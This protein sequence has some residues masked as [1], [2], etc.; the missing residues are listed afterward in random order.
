MLQLFQDSMA[1]VRH[2]GK[3][4]LFITFTANPKWKEI[5]DELLYDQ[6]AWDR[7]DLI[8]RVFRLKMLALL[9][10]L[11]ETQI[12]GRFKGYVWTIEYQKRG[13]PH[14]H[15]LLFLH[16]EDRFL[17]ADKI[18]QIVMAELPDAE[19]DPSGQLTELVKSMMVH[20]PCGEQAPRAPC[21]MSKDG[22]RTMTCSKKYPRAF[23]E[24]TSVLEDG[25]P[26]YRRRQ[27]GR[28]ISVKAPNNPGHIIQLDNRSVV[29]YN[30]Y[31]MKKYQAHINVEVCASVQAVKYIHK[32][33]Y[34]GGDRSTLELGS[35]NDE[36]KRYLQG[37]Y[38]GP[39]EAIWRLFE[40][41]LHQEFP[42]VIHLAI[43]LEGEQ[44]VSFPAGATTEQIQERMGSA[45]STLMA[46]FEY[47]RLNEDGWQLL[48]HE[49]PTK[50]VFDKKERI[51]RP[52]Q[53]GQAIGRMYHCNPFQG[54]KYYLRML[55]TVVRG[56]TSFDY[57]KIVH[58]QQ[59][60][61]Y[62]QACI[63]LG[64]LEDDQEWVHCFEK[65]VHFS[66]RNTLRTLFVTALMFGNVADPQSL[67]S[68]FGEKICDDLPYQLH[69]RTDIPPGLEHPHLDYGLFLL[70]Q[71]LT[72]FG[73]NLMD[74]HLPLPSHIWRPTE[75]NSLITAE[76]SYDIVEQ[77][78]VA[79]QRRDM[80]NSGQ[81]QCFQRI[82]NSL[83]QNPHRSHF[84]LQGPAGTGKTF[85]YNYLCCYYRGQG[86][87]VICVASSGIA[88]L[89]LPGG[90]TSHSR[91]KIPIQIHETSQCAISKN[92]QLA[93]LLR[94]TALII[95][96]KVPMQHKHCFDA[97]HRT[98]CDILDEE[99]HIF[100][101]IPII[102]GGDFA[103]ILPV[104]MKGTRA[105]TVDACFQR[106][107]IWPKL[108]VLHLTQNMR[109][110]NDAENRIFAAWV[111]SLPYLEEM[112][113]RIALL[114]NI[115]QLDDWGKF[116]L[117][118]YPKEILQNSCDNRAGFASKAIL[119]W[120]NETVSSFNEDLIIRMTGE[121]ETFH[122]SDSADIN[123]TEEEREELPVEYLN[124]ISPSELPPA[125]LKLKLGAPIILL[126]NLYPKQ[127]L[128]NGTR[129]T[130][131]RLGRR[132]LEGR[133]LGGDHDG[134]L[135]LLPRIKLTT[136]ET[137][138][139]FILSRKQFPIRL[140][141]AMTVN[142]AQGQSLQTVGMDLR[143]SAFA[144]GQFYVA[145][146][147]VTN[148]RKLFALWASDQERKTENIVYPEVLLIDN[149]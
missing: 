140:A 67:W 114:P 41:P 29:P 36:I 34:K 35:E 40:F 84:F 107:F 96:D 105:L 54:E 46:F 22:G 141:F 92:S 17:N 27:D 2:F 133:I 16:S 128:C 58:G 12:F 73:K 60:S 145:V 52:R 142:K 116:C 28:T 139:P 9:H 98:L 117:S 94:R 101:G 111:R 121:L 87:I 144:H 102:F 77:A 71:K 61:S 76:L 146:S 15:L 85:L 97:V 8:A 95:W 138:L 123:E 108:Q 10:D 80:L 103:Q 132:C 136:T 82:V 19:M 30:P 86:K 106:S 118:I 113:G 31:L 109:V 125:K 72:D 33:I 78:A 122:S 4:T 42:P 62:Q 23:Q 43:H 57:L 119:A 6:V 104:V 91:F 53:R 25:Y 110:I 51:W 143:T 135:R 45:R 39:T 13:L 18:D 55:L 47:N 26:I 88:S 83:E 131:T 38:I 130:I 20:G 89:L 99:K 48:Y 149:N 147:R 127:S 44:T 70:Q 7:P 120:Q 74:F 5:Q 137:E 126:R 37:R 93:A 124:S 1:I 75:S 69:Y 24:H 59:Y 134:E 129:L 32:Y 90:Q 56:P 50:Y 112:R 79:E 148:V 64:L 100:G 66:T 115:A 14:M 63:A 81:A 21:M 3:P 68:R 65:A 11:K 49:F